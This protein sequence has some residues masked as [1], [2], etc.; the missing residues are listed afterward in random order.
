M[1]SLNLRGSG[2]DLSSGDTMQVHLSYN[3]AVLTM[4]INDGVTYATYSTSFTVDIP[5]TIGTSTAYVGFTAG[6]GGQTASQK[7]M[8]WVFSKPV[9]SGTSSN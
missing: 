2:I 4:T 9:S 7:I 3:G 8:N 6:T 1:P 5:R